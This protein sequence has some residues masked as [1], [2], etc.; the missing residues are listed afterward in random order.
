MNGYTLLDLAKSLDPNGI[1]VDVASTLR[2]ASPLFEHMP[3]IQA[4][5]LDTH[6]FSVET[7]LPEIGVRRLNQGVP[8]SKGSKTQRVETLYRY[9]GWSEHD[10]IEI[11]MAPNPK[12]Y[13]YDMD[14]AYFSA[15]AMQANKDL[16]YAN[17]SLKADIGKS[18]G[19]ATRLSKIN[20]ENVFSVGGTGSNLS[21]IYIV[22]QHVTGCT[23]AY[24]KGLKNVGIYKDD[25]GVQTKQYTDDDGVERAL[26]VYRT[27]IGLAL[28]LVVQ[29]ENYIARVGNISTDT[30][31][32]ATKGK[33]IIDAV[34][35]AMN[36]IGDGPGDVR[37]YCS[38]GV[39]DILD[40]Y[41]SEKQIITNNT[42]DPFGRFIMNRAGANWYLDKQI[43]CNEKLIK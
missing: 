27:K 32:T 22:K 8:V 9:E 41:I 14:I 24:P 40:Q 35:K 36:R 37:I 33:D 13:R 4:N 7:K 11:D 31:S 26:D 43:A 15:L 21:S 1:L 19:L 29:K 34:N 30:G 23:L 28:G 16:Y 25:K 3:W 38:T 12:Q 17:P 18:K 5:G 20:G 10:V 39:K 2:Q 42:A 6:T